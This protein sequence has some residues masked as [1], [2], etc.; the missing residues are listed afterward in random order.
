MGN[1]QGNTEPSATEENDISSSDIETM[2]NKKEDSE[3][4]R[5]KQKKLRQ[6]IDEITISSLKS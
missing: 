3:K 4:F 5:N 6:C 1:Y 2:E